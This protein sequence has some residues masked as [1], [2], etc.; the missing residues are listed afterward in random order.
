M[1]KTKLTTLLCATI[2]LFAT[3]FSACKE[4]SDNT[5]T[6]PAPSPEPAPATS[7]ITL[8]TGEYGFDENGAF[9]ESENADGCELTATMYAHEGDSYTLQIDATFETAGRYYFVSDYGLDFGDENALTDTSLFDQTFPYYPCLTTTANETDTFYISIESIYDSETYEYELIHLPTQTAVMGENKDKDMS[10]IGNWEFTFTA[11]KAG[12]YQ[13]VPAANSAHMKL[14]V[15]GDGTYV[16]YFSHTNDDGA[17]IV[18]ATED[19]QTVSFFARFDQEKA[20]FTIAE[21][22]PEKFPASYPLNLE[23]NTSVTLDIAVKAGGST[24]IVIDGKALSQI[25]WT[26]ETLTYRFNDLEVTGTALLFAGKYQGRHT[27]TIINN[28]TTDSEQTLT[29][30]ELTGLPTGVSTIY[31][32]SSNDNRQFKFNSFTVETAMQLTVDET[33]AAIYKG[34]DLTALSE[35]TINPTDGAVSVQIAAKSADSVLTQITFVSVDE[36]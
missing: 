33:V 36:E 12:L 31:L 22:V 18:T 9:I 13:I 28:G 1:K 27:L 24:N 8:A 17:L 10:D 30:T 15:A 26:D 14:G 11:P 21:Y 19:N 3:A 16:D 2:A 6:P 4:E 25:A 34:Q 23:G 29:L 20:S 35:L 7:V 5:N 32:P